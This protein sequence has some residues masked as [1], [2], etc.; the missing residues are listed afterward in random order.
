METITA[1]T[2]SSM[3]HPASFG[4]NWVPTGVLSTVTI[5]KYFLTS[6]G[7]LLFLQDRSR[8]WPMTPDLKN[9]KSHN[10]QIYCPILIECLKNE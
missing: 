10:R 1:A 8:A 4:V 5:L 2:S 9:S 7:I 3:F 6:P